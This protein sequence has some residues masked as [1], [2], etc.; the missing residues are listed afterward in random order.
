MPRVVD[1]VVVAFGEG[2]AARDGGHKRRA[3]AGP[4][5]EPG[6]V[7][8]VRH[9]HVY[10]PI[11][12]ALDVPEQD[13]P[14]IP[15]VGVDEDRGYGPL[16]RGISQLLVGELV[17]V[18]ELLCAGYAEDEAGSLPVERPRDDALELRRHALHPPV[19]VPVDLLHG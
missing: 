14:C 3:Y 12:V 13:R 2:V 10:P 15:V 1:V 17:I 5:L 11:G 6:H 8:T 18:T 4:A 19:G 7:R 16:H 9:D